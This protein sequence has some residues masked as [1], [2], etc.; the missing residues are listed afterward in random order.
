[1]RGKTE[2]EALVSTR[3]LGLERESS[4]KTWL[5][6]PAGRTRT[7]CWPPTFLKKPRNKGHSIPELDLRGCCD[8]SRDWS[9]ERMTTRTLSRSRTN[10]WSRTNR[11][12]LMGVDQEGL[13][14]HRRGRRG[15]R[16]CLYTP[17]QGRLPN[18]VSLGGKLP[19]ILNVISHQKIV[20]VKGQVSQE[21]PLEHEAIGF[22]NP[23]VTRQAATHFTHQG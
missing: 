23:V 13:I 16:D 7:S 2:T 9:Q 22:V 11:R 1:M 6:S 5:E 14:W 21:E 19:R 12:P 15:C 20:D 4:K 10:T 17:V 3:N 8:T 18:C